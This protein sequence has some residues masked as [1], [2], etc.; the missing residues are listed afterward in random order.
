MTIKNDAKFGKE[1]FCQEIYNGGF[2]DSFMQ[3]KIIQRQAVNITL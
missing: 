1:L 2:W 3:T